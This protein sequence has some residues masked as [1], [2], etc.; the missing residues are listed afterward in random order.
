MHQEVMKT[1]HGGEHGTTFNSS[2]LVKVGDGVRW[3]CALVLTGDED[4]KAAEAS[5][6]SAKADM[7]EAFWEGPYGVL[8]A[9]DVGLV[10]ATDHVN[11]I[12]RTGAQSE[13]LGM[14]PEMTEDEYKE[15]YAEQRADGKWYYRVSAT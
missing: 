11:T 3:S 7:A 14:Y 1:G 2:C 15:K 9:D 10:P 5:L 13:L 4:E 6:S 8:V 12:D